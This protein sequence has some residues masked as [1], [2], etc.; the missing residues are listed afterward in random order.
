M[1]GNVLCS[2]RETFPCISVPSEISAHSVRA[3]CLS[4]RYAAESPRRWKCMYSKSNIF[5]DHI[6]YLSLCWNY[7]FHLF[8]FFSLTISYHFLFLF[9]KGLFYFISGPF[10]LS[11]GPALRCIA[12]TLH[13]TPTSRFRSYNIFRASCVITGRKYDEEITFSIK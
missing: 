2:V 1:F 7:L 6:F 9:S 5:C 10:F 8:R 12:R 13:Y 11:A 4:L 3:R